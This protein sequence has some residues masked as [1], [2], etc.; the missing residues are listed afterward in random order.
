MAATSFDDEDLVEDTPTVE[1]FIQFL[2]KASATPVKKRLLKDFLQKELPYEEPRISPPED[3]AEVKRDLIED[4]ERTWVSS[5]HANTTQ[6]SSWA[7]AAF[8]NMPISE[9]QN[10]RQDLRLAQEICD[11]A[12]TFCRLCTY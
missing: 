3:E 5:Q 1:D 10:I 9:L 11:S 4:I 6:L 7:I 2:A 8:F 12:E